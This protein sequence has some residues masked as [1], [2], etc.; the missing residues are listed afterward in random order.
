MRGFIVLLAL[1]LPAGAGADD[2]EQPGAPKKPCVT[3]TTEARYVNYGYD[4][5]VQLQS[6]CETRQS[7]SVKTDVAPAPTIVEIAP[8][9][10]K[11]LTTFRG[12]PA[13]EFKAYVT[14]TPLK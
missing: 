6:A 5:L 13:R 8:R 14:C 7:C 3:V 2:S 10:T 4:H 9:E 1:L 12:S 11:T